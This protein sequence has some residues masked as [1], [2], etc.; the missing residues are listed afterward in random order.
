MKKQFEKN[1]DGVTVLEKAPVITGEEVLSPLTG[2]V[3]PLSEAD[4]EV[5]ASGAVG[6]GVVIVPE[7]NIIYAP[8]DG[9]VS[10]IFPSKHAIGLIS[11]KGAEVLIH[12]GI[13][14]VDLAGRGFEA[15]VKDGDRI[16]FGQ[17]LIQFDV[18]VIEE[19]GLSTQ[20]MIIVTNKADY[21]D[22][23]FSEETYR[24]A[25]SSLMTLKK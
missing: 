21:S 9:V 6:D 7:D 17:P 11:D 15:F 8:F 12:I 18:S 23:T 19:A 13:N 2:Q 4:D 25:K 3:L 22:V 5:F 20:N 1:V 16:V 10:S 14:T 24:K